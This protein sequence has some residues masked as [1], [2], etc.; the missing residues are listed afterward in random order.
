MKNWAYYITG[1]NPENLE[2]HSP[3]SI[4]KV[5][6]LASVILLPAIIW[7]ML[8]FC[9]GS[10]F[11]Q[12]GFGASLLC[13]TVAGTVV[14]LVDRLIIMT[15]SNNNWIKGSRVVLAIMVAVLGSIVADHVV[16]EDDIKM[17][18]ATVQSEQQRASE[19][20]VENERAQRIEEL[21]LNVENSKNQAKSA[22]TEFLKEADGT[23]GTGQRG[24]GAIAK[25]KK[26]AWVSA[27]SEFRAAQEAYD[28]ELSE[29]EAEKILASQLV[30]ENFSENALLTQI[31][32]MFRFLRENPIAFIFWGPFTL[33]MFILEILPVLI[34]S[35]MDDSAY[36]TE[37]R[38]LEEVRKRRVELMRTEFE[39]QFNEQS[40]Y[41]QSD[42]G[43][44]RVLSNYQVNSIAS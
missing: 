35:N 37:L 6:I 25:V 41:T 19:L 9:F 7:L 40:Q 24:L 26:E 13:G 28:K 31:K 10:T 29:A 38:Y 20:V 15:N 23:G 44:M 8:G 4:R 21:R 43:A 5:K 12:M 30:Q 22:K 1:D 42:R 32:A 27:Q 34:K 17:M 2:G 11:L 36:E 39:Q 33:I 18:M 3:E 16:F 14:F